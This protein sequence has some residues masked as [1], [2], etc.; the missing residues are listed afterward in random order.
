MVGDF[1]PEANQHW[2]N[3]LLMI[4]ITDYLMAPQLYHCKNE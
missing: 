1:V 4:E 2:E 3:Y